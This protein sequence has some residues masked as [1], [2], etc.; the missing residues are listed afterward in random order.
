MGTMSR[1]TDCS[2]NITGNS[3]S[4][5]RAMAGEVFLSVRDSVRSSDPVELYECARCEWLGV[6]QSGRW[7]NQSRGVGA[8]RVQRL[9]LSNCGTDPRR[10]NTG[11]P[12][13]TVPGND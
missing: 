11:G 4:C 8:G 10:G 13:N 1:S 9:H 5:G 3:K 7:S 2:W 6:V 12:G